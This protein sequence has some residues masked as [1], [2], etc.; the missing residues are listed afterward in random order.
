MTIEAALP[1]LKE[2]NHELTERIRRGKYTPSPV[3]RVE[4]PKPDGGIRKLGIPTVIDRII[5]QAMLQQLMPIYEPLFS[6]GQL[7]LSTGKRGK[8]RYLQDKRV[9]RTGISQGQSSLTCRKYFDTLNHD[10]PA[11]PAEKTDKR[12][13]GHTDGQAILEK[14]GDGKRCCNR[15]RGRL[16]AGRKSLPTL[17]KCISE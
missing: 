4:I 11:E 3:R 10:N 5:Q 1:W 15:D 13:E 2:H 6:D 8:R 14:R 16:P 7:W 17:S 9:Y 12:R